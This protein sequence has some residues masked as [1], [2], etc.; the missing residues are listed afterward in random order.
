MTWAKLDDSFP[1]NIKISGLSDRLFR[2]HVTAICYAARN[3]TDGEIPENQL[4]KLGGNQKLAK[5]LSEAGL[6]ETTSRGSYVIHD[7]LEYNPSRADVDA[8]RERKRL[9]GQAGGQARAKALAQARAKAPVQAPANRSATGNSGAPV[10]VPVPLTAS[11]EAVVARDDGD[12]FDNVIDIGFRDRYGTLVTAFGG[13]VDERVADE[14]RQMASDYTLAQINEAITLA[15]RAKAGQLYPSRI[16]RFLPDLM[17]TVAP[18]PAQ[19]GEFK[20]RNVWD[21]MAPIPGEAP[22]ED[23]DE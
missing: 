19:H 23:D 4:R 20:L 2:L 10:P 14:F 1:E 12:D 16:S 6:W 21:M 7:Y 3:L 17:P 9:A 18:K 8:E 5:A 15:R 13:R 11:N 22:P